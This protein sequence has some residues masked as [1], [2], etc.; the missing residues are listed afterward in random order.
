VCSQPETTGAL[1]QEKAMAKFKFGGILGYA[2]IWAFFGLFLIYPLCRL[3][4]DAFTTADG[5]FT[6]NNFID[7]FQDSYYLKAMFNSIV[8]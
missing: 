7:F 4:Y 3:F 2:A 1:S 5:A 8:L 6:P